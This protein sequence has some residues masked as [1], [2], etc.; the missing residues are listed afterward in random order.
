MRVALNAAFLD[1][2][3]SGGTETYVRSLA[4]ALSAVGVEPVV[5]TSRRGAAALRADG[6]SDVVGLH[7]DEGERWRR[8]VAEQIAVPREARRR[9]CVLVHSLGNTGPVMGGIP[10]A[11]TVLDAQAWTTNALSP[12]SAFI[13]RRLIG[14]AARRA[15]VLLAI[16]HA[17]RDEVART[18]GLDPRRF[19]VTPL[20]PGRDPAEP[21]D[22]ETVRRRHDL[23]G[24]VVLCVAAKRPHKNQELLLRALPEGAMLVLVGHAEAYDARL[25]AIAVELGMASR[26]RFLEHVPAAELEALWQLADCAALPTRSEG[27][28]LPLVEAMRRGV[29]VA[30][31][32]I[33][34]LREI[35]AGVPHYFDPEDPDT[36]RVAISRALR[37]E[38]STGVERAGAF[39]WLACAH[40]T[41]AA[42]ERALG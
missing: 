18:V 10:H 23:R 6:W 14:A 32:D 13:Y 34:V 36:A 38:G 17:M 39:T 19:V 28:G 24:D 29:S 3:V 30:C 9:G 2:G 40:A 22:L 26:V 11:L 21:E 41:R 37:A 7:A 5:L 31:S 33:P 4:P 27:F 8:L 25:R 16:S 12:T 20:G 15:D 1:P 35:G 42:Y